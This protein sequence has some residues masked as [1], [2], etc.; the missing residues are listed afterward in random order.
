MAF[1]SFLNDS[2]D[3]TQDERNKEK[4]TFFK[5]LRKIFP[6]PK[7][8]HSSYP[9]VKVGRLG[10]VRQY[11]RSDIGTSLINLTKNFFLSQNRTGCR[12]LTVDAYNEEPQIKFYLKNGFQ[13]LWDEDRDDK[14]RIMYFDLLRHEPEES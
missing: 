5:I 11:Q 13:F 4:K 1:V 14:T 9:A 12:F 10:V 6:F 7:W 2:I 3:I 8:R